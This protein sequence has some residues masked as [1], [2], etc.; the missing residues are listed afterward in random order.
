MKRII[1]LIILILPIFCFAKV[2]KLE[3]VNEIMNRFFE[4]HVENKEL[5]ETI[6]K[7]WFKGYI[8]QFDPGRIYLLQ[9]E[10][11]PFLDINTKDAKKIIARISQKDFSD[12]RLSQ[13]QGWSQRYML[14]YLHK[15]K[16]YKKLLSPGFQLYG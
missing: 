3:D 2:L 5:N 1:V 8:D 13:S 15:L 11:L 4:Y 12:P 9:E 16:G 6:V 7:R 14:N 10:V